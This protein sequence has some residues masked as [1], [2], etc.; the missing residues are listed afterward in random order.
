MGLF[1]FPPIENNW[2]WSY[3]LLLINYETKC[4]SE[5][6]PGLYVIQ[7]QIQAV[8]I[9]NITCSCIFKV[10]RLIRRQAIFWTV[11]PV[12]SST[13][14]MKIFSIFS[15]CFG[16]A[17]RFFKNFCT[18]FVCAV[19]KCFPTMSKRKLARLLSSRFDLSD[20]TSYEKS[21]IFNSKKICL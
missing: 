4:P 14:Y 20:L 3:Q 16:G 11:F 2:K 10:Y 21:E 8:W 7:I 5:L 6:M 18:N 9:N 12:K 19:I 15:N 1:P 17:P 13:Y